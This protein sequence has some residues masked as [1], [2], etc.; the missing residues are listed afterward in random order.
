[1]RIWTWKT[2]NPA[3]IKTAEAP[4]RWLKY[5]IIAVFL[6]L[7]VLGW[8][9]LLSG[10]D[11][12]LFWGVNLGFF[13]PFFALEWGVGYNAFMRHRMPWLISWLIPGVYMYLFDSLAVNQGIW[14]FDYKFTTN[15]WLFNVVN[16]EVLVVYLF[17]AKAVSLPIFWMLDKYD[18]KK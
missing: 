10:I 3:K 7:G 15:T 8:K 12:Y 13:A 6:L 17:I 16:I 5:S 11:A 1:M 9:L 14:I 18:G 2:D 4:G